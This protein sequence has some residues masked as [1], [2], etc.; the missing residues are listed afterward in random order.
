MRLPG[1][2]ASKVVALGLLGLVSACSSKGAEQRMQERMKQEEELKKKQRAE[3]AAREAAENPP[4]PPPVKLDSYWDDPAY[5]KLVP[6]GACPDG[7]WALFPGDAPGADA[8]AKKENAAKR[9]DLAKSLREKTYV[10][11]LNPANGV[12]L[13]DYEPPAGRFPI[14]VVGT[15]D[16]SDSIGRVAIVWGENAKATNPGNSAAKEGAEVAQNV[17]TAQ[18]MRY[19]LPM[20]MAEAKE[21]SAKHKVDLGARLVFKLG[22]TEVDKKIFRTSKISEKTVAGDLSFGGGAED[23][24]AGRMVRAERVGVRLSVDREATALTENKGK[25]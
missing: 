24:G 8:A 12:S 13:K 4:P 19:Y 18:P 9:A 6:D 22:K 3:K 11:K 7:F 23:W 25:D 17:W 1:E 5:V 20:K 21:F 15:V 16:C 10:I 14:E 2:F